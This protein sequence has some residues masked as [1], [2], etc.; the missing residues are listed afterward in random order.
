MNMNININIF[1]NIPLQ[2][3]CVNVGNFIAKGDNVT[4]SIRTFQNVD[5]DN[6]AMEKSIPPRN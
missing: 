1:K 4:A 2:S 5:K 3:T 6:D